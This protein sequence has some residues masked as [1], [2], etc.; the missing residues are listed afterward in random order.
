MRLIPCAPIH[1]FLVNKKTVTPDQTKSDDDQPLQKK[2]WLLIPQ[3]SDVKSWLMHPDNWRQL[4]ES[5]GDFGILWGKTCN[6]NV[7]SGGEEATPLTKRPC[8]GRAWEVSSQ[9]SLFWGQVNNF[10]H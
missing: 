9:T 8:G 10:A 4:R 6:C 3:T 7:Y 2:T 1:K 5:L